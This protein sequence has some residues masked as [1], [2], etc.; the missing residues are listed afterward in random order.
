MTSKQALLKKLDRATDRVVSVAVKQGVPLPISE[1]II[2][3]GNVYIR[4]NRN[5]THDILRLNK[6]LLET[7]IYSYNAAI[8]I[9][10]KYNIDDYANIKK[11]LYLDNRYSK[12]HTDVLNYTRCLSSAKKNNDFERCL[13]L[14]DKLAEA[15]L[16][17][18]NLLN[19]ITAYKL[20]K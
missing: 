8:I 2:L 1:K 12:Y 5:S 11:I 17:A 4:K 7:D 18:K 13:V 20:S 15:D 6:S 9:A 3:V 16:Q 10:Q 14:E 19:Q